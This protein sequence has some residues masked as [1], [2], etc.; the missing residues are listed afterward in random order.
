MVKHGE[1]CLVVALKC[2]STGSVRLIDDKRRFS[3]LFNRN[4]FLRVQIFRSAVK[5]FCHT[6]SHSISFRTDLS[7]H[8]HRSR[9]HRQL[10]GTLMYRARE[11]KG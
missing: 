11:R 5:T 4:E 3:C 10:S 7:S 8:L 9:I 6:T 1:D 2:A